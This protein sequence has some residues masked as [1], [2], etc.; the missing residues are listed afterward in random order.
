MAGFLRDLLDA[1]EPVFSLS[2]RQLEQASGEQ[3]RDVQLIGDIIQKIRYST[4]QLGL[5]PN[6]T[7]GLELYA[8]QMTRFERDNNRLASLLGSEE[9]DDIE[10]MSKRILKQA[11]TSTSELSVWVLKRSVAK[12]LLRKMPPKKL[13]K[14]LGHRSVDAL[15]KHESVDELYL[16]IRFS[17]G[18]AWLKKFNEQFKLVRPT[19]FES[20]N[21]SFVGLDTKK[22]GETGKVYLEARLH[23]V[24]HSKELGVVGLLPIVQSKARGV[25]LQ[26]LALLLHYVNE[27]KLYSTF[28]KLK[29]VGA[30]FGEVVADTLSADPA[31]ASQMAGQYVHWRVIQRY[32]GEMDDEVRSIALQPHIQPEDLIWQKTE[33]LLALIDPEMGF[34]R[35]QS[36]VGKVYDGLPISFN[37]LDVAI[38]Y[39]RKL[40]YKE[41]YYKHFRNS[42]WNEIFVRYMGSQNLTQQVL[43][44]LDENEVAPEYLNLSS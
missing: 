9:A 24:L 31:T 13:M 38:N 1:D 16:G 27:V 36:Y 15:V 40:S 11:K 37:L 39:S 18:E 7:T 35:G 21:I 8:A 14:Q 44:R 43:G 3:G 20:R 42:L 33:D 22:Y 29:Q 5:D 2:L 19:D 17:E 25:T 34:W 32:F 30:D 28:F 6:D 12:E 26:N 10:A 4:A 41:R 23:N